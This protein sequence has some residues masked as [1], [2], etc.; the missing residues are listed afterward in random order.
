M[1]AY[2]QAATR[3]EGQIASLSLPAVLCD[4][5]SHAGDA[6]DTVGSWPHSPPAPAQ[7]GRAAR[8]V[9]VRTKS[10]A[11]MGAPPFLLMGSAR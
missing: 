1:S 10:E 11:C 6:Q 4:G 9:V 5:A 8:S 3:A 7:G 2:S